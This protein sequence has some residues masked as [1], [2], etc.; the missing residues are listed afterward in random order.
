M[1]PIGNFGQVNVTSIH[2]QYCRP[3]TTR[4]RETSTRTDQQFF[5]TRKTALSIVVRIDTIILVPTRGVV[6]PTAAHQWH[7]WVQSP[8]EGLLTLS[9][10]SSLQS[11]RIWGE[12]MLHEI[13]C[14]RHL[15]LWGRGGLEESGGWALGRKRKRKGEEKE[16]IPLCSPPNNYLTIASPF[17]RIKLIDNPSTG[18]C[19]RLCLLMRCDCRIDKPS[20]RVVSTIIHSYGS[21]E[22]FHGSSQIVDLYKW[23][24]FFPG[25]HHVHSIGQS[26]HELYARAIWKNFQIS[27]VL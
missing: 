1:V 12:R 27:R 25:S 2:V 9:I 10:R 8:V 19:N 24:L 16:K 23:K 22:L 17:V 13:Q 15:G 18:I 5:M 3:D 7:K 26:L 11:R 21:T 14:G 6:H 20:C 4:K